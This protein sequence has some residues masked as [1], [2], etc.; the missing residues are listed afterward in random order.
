M[1]GL[2]LQIILAGMCAGGIDILRKGNDVN[3]EDKWNKVMIGAGVKVKGDEGATFSISKKIKRIYGYDLIIAIP[4]GMTYTALEELQEQIKI[5]FKCYEVHMEYKRKGGCAYVRLITEPLSD[6][7]PFQPV[8]VKPWELYLGTTKYHKDVIVSMRN[9]P[10][11]LIAGV[12]G[13]GK[14]L[15]TIQTLLNM[16]VNHSKEECNVYIS[17]ISDKDDFKL[18][19]KCDIVKGYVRTLADTA[20]MLKHLYDMM[21]VRSRL[22]NQFDDVNELYDYNAKFPHKQLPYIYFFTDEYSLF[23]EDESDTDQEDFLKKQCQAY[24]KKL[25]KLA[26]NAGIYV[27]SS[28]QRPDKESMPP[29][30]KTNLNVIVAFKQRNGASALTVLDSYEPM[31]LEYREAI[32]DFGGGQHIIY[33]L[34]INSYIVK[35]YLEDKKEEQHEYTDLSEHEWLIRQSKQHKKDKRKKK[36]SGE[37][38]GLLTIEET[39]STSTATNLDNVVSIDN[40]ANK[41][42]N[43]R[44]KGKGKGVIE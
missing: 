29:I 23:M 8:K 22:F 33:S 13:A 41:G 10:H 25:A 20:K 37:N 18:F 15:F 2:A 39:A 9:F 28:L 11:T 40:P 14:S 30:F 31:K 43:G 5:S 1:V 6:D 34:Y 35:C 32:V 4:D 19:R 3:I 17:E 36:A 24:M 21:G 26:R 27:L 7:T 12:T 38:G 42:K 16:V 44:G